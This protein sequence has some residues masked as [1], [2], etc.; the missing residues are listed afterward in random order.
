MQVRGRKRSTPTFL[1]MQRLVAK[2][3]VEYTSLSQP[4]FIEHS[5]VCFYLGYDIL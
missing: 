2:I 3:V 5:H 1:Y 4:G